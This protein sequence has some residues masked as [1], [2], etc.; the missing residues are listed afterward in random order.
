M[1]ENHKCIKFLKTDNGL[2][3]PVQ[4]TLEKKRNQDA[5]DIDSLEIRSDGYYSQKFIILS[6]QTNYELLKN[7]YNSITYLN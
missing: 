3:F 7:H 2:V 6:V 1:N 5:S 4:G